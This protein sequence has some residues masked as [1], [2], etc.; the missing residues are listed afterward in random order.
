MI[1]GTNSES[2][3][4]SLVS[5]A[6]ADGIFSDAPVEYQPICGDGSD[7]RFF[8]VGQGNLH[9]IAIVSPRQKQEGTDE[10]DSYLRI[11]KHLYRHL[12]PVPRIYW[13]NTDH[14]CFL[15]EDVGDSHLQQYAD[16]TRVNVRALYKRVIELLIHLHQKAPDGFEPGFCF[17]SPLYDPPFVYTREL[18]YFR[19]AFAVT[20][21][22]TEVSAEDLR[23]DFENLAEAAGVDKT[24]L[25]LHRDFQSRNIMIHHDKLR[26]LDFQGMRF[27]PPVYDLASLLVDPYVKLPGNVQEGLVEMYWPAIRGMLNCSHREFMESYKALRLCRNLQAL[28]A[29]G[30]LGVVK[31]KKQFLSYIPQAWKQLHK[32]INGPCGG[33]YPSLQKWINAVDHSGLPGKSELERATAG[34]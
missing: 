4:S 6:H 24:S 29:Y 12:I 21:L 7:R 34:K 11:G 26:L 14:G 13:A 30:Y 1:I 32:W 28:G 15:I 31:G 27:G 8:R 18:E 5:L 17:D 33:R 10:N 9:F 16:T 2:G 22:G 20:Y 25:V 23:S 19:K 3:L